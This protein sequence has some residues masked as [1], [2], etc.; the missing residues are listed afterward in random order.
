[1]GNIIINLFRD[2]I[3][4]LL[5]AQN[6]N[7]SPIIIN[8]YHHKLLGLNDN[9][10]NKY[11]EIYL[12]NT[13]IIL[14]DICDFGKSEKIK[15]RILKNKKMYFSFPLGGILTKNIIFDKLDKLLRGIT[16]KIEKKIIK[17]YRS[18]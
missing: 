6:V 15:K 7:N 2:K 11:K 18:I 13:L 8:N 16:K 12:N 3:T 9:F 14:S 17:M 4:E 10:K 5:I 1:M